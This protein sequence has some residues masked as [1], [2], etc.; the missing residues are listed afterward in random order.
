MKRFAFSP[1]ARTSA[2]AAAPLDADE[3]L[4]SDIA[5]LARKYRRANGPIMTIVNRFGGKLEAQARLLPDALRRQ[6]EAVVVKALQASMSVAA[7]SER[8]PD[9]GR[10]GTMAAAIASGAAGGAGGIATALAELP[11][12]VT[13]IMHAIRQEARAEGFDPEDPA[14]RMECLQVFA[15]ATPLS[16]DDGV[17][18]GFL[19][20]RLTVTGGVLHGMVAAVAPKLAAVMGQKLAAQTIPVL[21]AI[22][23][24]AMN[25]AFLDYYRSMARIR[26]A[27][28]RLGAVYGTDKVLED[29]AYAVEHK[30][31]QG[32]KG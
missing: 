32:P 26:F 8:L 15:A 2:D 30:K 10:K 22:S 20:A 9:P 21:G 28:L 12:T 19:S 31:L 23:G 18:T 27:L 24:A 5:D 4:A 17:N 3:A 7:Q 29:F 11:V 16:S 6:L 13:V 1:A 14:I 25:A